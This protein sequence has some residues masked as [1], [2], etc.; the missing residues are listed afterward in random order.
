[1]IGKISSVAALN[2]PP[3]STSSSSS[4][5]GSHRSLSSSSPFFLQRKPTNSSNSEFVGKPSFFVSRGSH[6]NRWSKSRTMMMQMSTMRPAT[7]DWDQN[8]ANSVSLI[9][10]IGSDPELRRLQNGSTVCEVSLAVQKRRK[11]T[12]N[13]DGNGADDNENNY[14]QNN[15]GYMT[16]NQDAEDK[17]CEWYSI[18][19]WNEEAERLSEHVRKGS[20]LCVQGRLAT[21]TWVDKVTGQNRSKAKVILNQFSF[22]ASTARGGGG[23]GTNYNNNRYEEQQQQQQQQQQSN[24]YEPQTPPP[25]QRM[26]QQQQ[27]QQ[28]QQQTR[29]SKPPPPPPPPSGGGYQSPKDALWRSVFDAPDRWWDNRENKRNPKAPDYKHKESGEGLWVNGRDTPPWVNERLMGGAAAAGAGAMIG[30]TANV[31]SSDG[32]YGASR[33]TGFNNPYGNQ[34]PDY[35]QPYDANQTSQNFGGGYEPAQEWNDDEVPF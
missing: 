17:N 6:S 28:F 1:M 29:A 18:V 20:K 31:S 5:F 25:Q 34:E 27:P 21:D 9:G 32:Y 8:L 33:G 3:S 26:Q 16:M 2:S 12:Q 19:A 35:S 11:R 10:L 23:D 30:G 15:K 14:E 13:D 24:G 4:F 22:V 7:V